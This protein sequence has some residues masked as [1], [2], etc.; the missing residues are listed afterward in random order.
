MADLV[1]LELHDVDVVGLD[2]LAGGGDGAALAR[3]GRAEDAEAGDVPALLV[4]GERLDLVAGIRGERVA[5]LHPVGVGL[6]RPDLGERIGL[7]R[8]G[9]AGRAV[10]LADVPALAGFAGVEE[11][12][13]GFFHRGHGV[14]SRAD[15]SGG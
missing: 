2:G 3:V 5:A 13:G 10:L 12:P 14:I 11:L 4:D 1:A 6:E 9:G 15:C 7:R 8:E